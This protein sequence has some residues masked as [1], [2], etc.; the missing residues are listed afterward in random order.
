MNSTVPAFALLAAFSLSASAADWKNWRGP[1]GLGVS[2]DHGFP[3]Q[4]SRTNHVA[5]SRDLP[6]RGASSPVTAG[7]RIYVTSQTPDTGLHLLALDRA[8]GA[9]VW[10]REIGQGKARAHQ[11]HNMATPTPVT[12]GRHIW[13]L[14]GTG[15]FAC[16][17]RAGTVTWHRNLSKEYGAYNANH[18]YGSSPMLL[19]GRVYVTFMHQGPSFLLAA[20]AATGKN[21]WKTDRNFPARE[22]GKDSYSS[23][24]FVR[25]GD[26]TDVVLAGA[27]ALNAYDPATG[28]ERWI[29]QGLEAP[30]PYGRTIAGATAGEG[31][32]VTVTSGF[33]NRGQTVAVKAGGTGDITATHRAWSL[34]KFSPD[35]PTPVIH[36][37]LLFTIRDDGM[38]SCVDL[39]SGQPHWQE[40]LFSDNVK[41]SPVAA[42]GRIYFTS[43]QANCVVVKADARFEVLARNEWNA[44]TL[45]S[46][47]LSDG[48][49]YL[50][51][52]S[53]LACLADQ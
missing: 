37:G 53:G 21:V 9:T 22:E 27:E 16:V 43:G 23:P 24:L 45:S 15:D 30:H 52:L 41:V 36:R 10:D 12:D 29:F 26:R 38:A 31:L 39:K 46:P 3:V 2:A 11:L 49:I 42:D 4:W 14:F 5:W 17:D 18:G 34:T 25:T 40:R 13:V 51:T 33:Q 32:I 6:G 48:R 35:C 50:R 1:D 20:D 47:A 7:D 28:Q 8:S 19:D 44:E